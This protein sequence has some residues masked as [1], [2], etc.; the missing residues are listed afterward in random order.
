MIDISRVINTLSDFVNL[1]LDLVHFWN[2]VPISIERVADTQDLV[3]Y[4]FAVPK[5]YQVHGL[6]WSCDLI[7]ECS[8]INEVMSE[9]KG[10]TFGDSEDEALQSLDIDG[11][12]NTGDLVEVTGAVA[13]CLVKQLLLL[14]A[15][16]VAGLCSSLLES[17]FHIGKHLLCSLHNLETVHQIGHR[18]LGLFQLCTLGLNKRFLLGDLSLNFFEEKVKCLLL[19]RTDVLELVQEAIYVLWWV[20]LNSVLLAFLMQK[21]KQSL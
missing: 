12:D 7:I 8:L 9:D 16:N 21:L 1:T 6:N 10:F 19:L 14:T 11:V 4:Q 5:H 17:L 2:L 13:R 3:P 18:L 15:F 20:N